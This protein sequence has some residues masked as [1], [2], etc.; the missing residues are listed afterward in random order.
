M[1]VLRVL[2][3]FSNAARS[4][5]ASLPLRLLEGL[6]VLAICAL[7]TWWLMQGMA[8][9]PLPV[10]PQLGN[11]TTAAAQALAPDALLDSARLFG[12]RRPGSLSDNIQA[13]G[14]IADRGGHGSAL[15]SVDGQPARRYRVGDDLDGRRIT[16]IRRGEIEFE[17]AGVRQSMRLNLPE[18][19]TA[20]V[21]KH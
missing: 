19:P 16:A 3:P 7:A 8:G 15:I 4:R 10:A 6:L 12:A 21:V 1:S 13:V 18:V 20:G 17:S 9:P 2:N 5:R 14:M 11:T